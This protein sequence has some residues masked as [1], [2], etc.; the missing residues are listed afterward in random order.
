MQVFCKSIAHSNRIRTY[1]TSH[2]EQR[3]P[4]KST[5]R[6]TVNGTVNERRLHGKRINGN[7]TNTA[8]K[9]NGYETKSHLFHE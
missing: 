8:Y 7:L 1:H 9:Y 2:D 4:R 5:E 3:I 6:T